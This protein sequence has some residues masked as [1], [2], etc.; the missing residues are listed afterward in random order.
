MEAGKIISARDAVR[1]VLVMENPALPGQW[2]ATPNLYAGLQLLLPGETAPT[3]RHTQSAFRFVLEGSGAY[4][5]VDGERAYMERGDLILTPRWTWHDHVNQGAEPV[6]WLDGLDIPIVQQLGTGFAETA[7]YETQTQTRPSGDSL[8]RFG[9][10]LLPL[11]SCSRT[12][13]PVFCY[14]YARTRSA[15]EK[16]RAGPIDPHQ[17]VCLRFSNPLNGR[18][19]LSTLSAFIQLLPARFDGATSRSTDA[20]VMCVVEGEGKTFVGDVVLEWSANDIFVIPGWLPFRHSVANEDTVLFGFS[21]RAVQDV[22][23]LWREDKQ[24]GGLTG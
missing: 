16:L 22:L 15:L 8:A 13:S 2:R 21:D 7:S 19:A 24:L 10:N 9:S 3:H 20:K 12:E 14:P 6:I 4:T 1:R 18:D 23:G 5:A 11:D 17:G